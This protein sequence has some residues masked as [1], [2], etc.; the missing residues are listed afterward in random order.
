MIWAGSR[1]IA[2]ETLVYI[3][4]SILIKVVL[5]TEA[6]AR[7]LEKLDF[8][9]VRGSETIIS[10]ISSEDSGCAISDRRTLQL[11]P[12]PEMRWRPCGSQSGQEKGPR[13]SFC[14][15]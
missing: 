12:S 1:Y 4:T 6:T 10:S 9:R 2:L 13:R 8:G 15:P 7:Q 3:A 11:S 5:I 14:R